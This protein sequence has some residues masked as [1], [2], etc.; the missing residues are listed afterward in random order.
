[1]NLGIKV[2]FSYNGVSVHHVCEVWRLYTQQLPHVQI[3]E[4]I[5]DIRDPLVVQDNESCFRVDLW[6]L[7]Y[8]SSEWLPAHHWNACQAQGNS[9]FHM[10]G[11]PYLWAKW[12]FP[13][14]NGGSWGTGRSGEA[15]QYTTWSCRHYRCMQATGFAKSRISNRLI[16]MLL[17]KF[18]PFKALLRCT[19]IY[20]HLLHI[21]YCIVQSWHL[22]FMW[23]IG[24]KNSLGCWH[25]CGKWECSWVLWQTR[26][27]QNTWE[28][29][30]WK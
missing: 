4:F 17:T 11:A 19:V 28:L 26:V 10:R 6:I 27:Q 9:K 2:T 5:A 24:S 12:I 15:V 29:E 21:L 8:N 3:I 14:S 20:L 7:Q 13:R 16:K 18:G 30:T 22:T 25:W 23:P 1:M